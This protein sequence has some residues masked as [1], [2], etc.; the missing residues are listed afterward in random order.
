MKRRIA[1]T[2]GF[3][4]VLFLLGTIG[5][6]FL[7]SV[8]GNPDQA[9]SPVLAMPKEYVNYTI[10]RIDGTFWAIIDGSYPIYLLIQK[11]DTA[12]CDISEKL[13]MV[14]PTPPGTTNITLRLNG[15][16]LPWSNYTEA[17][18]G[19][20]HHTAIGDWP[21]IFA[22]IGPVS[23]YFLLSIH[24]E[25][26]LTI[27]NGSFLFLYDL[28]IAPYLSPESNS[29]VATFTVHFETEVENIRAYTTKTDSIWN[30]KD[31]S[32]TNES[33]AET[34]TII[35]NSALNEPL[36]GDLIVMFSDTPD[37]SLAGFLPWIA[38]LG[39]LTIV[40]IVAII[41]RNRRR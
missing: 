33:G 9:A 18:P 10:T 28:N 38:L 17:Y 25:H 4:A 32:K 20:L 37:Q 21:M 11:N 13:P 23:D 2:A 14:Y 15:T 40:V 3:F 29:S 6:Q 22:M 1:L 27:V 30:K 24:Y 19:N 16:V 35:M 31:F 12:Q 39:L 7:E 34:L 5:S 8:K 26:P 36:E 41:Y